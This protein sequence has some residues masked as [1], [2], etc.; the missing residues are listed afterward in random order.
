MANTNLFQF[1]LIHCC[2]LG[3]TGHSRTKVNKVNSTGGVQKLASDVEEFEMMKNYMFITT[4]MVSGGC[5]MV[6]SNSCVYVD[7]V[8]VLDIY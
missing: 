5:L 4:R 1:S 2:L 6:F 7:F 3:K 8:F